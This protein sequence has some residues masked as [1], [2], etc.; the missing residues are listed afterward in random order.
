MSKMTITNGVIASLS[1]AVTTRNIAGFSCR[2]H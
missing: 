2:W 1:L